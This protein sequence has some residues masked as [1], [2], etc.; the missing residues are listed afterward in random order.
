VVLYEERAAA[1]RLT[2]APNFQGQIYNEA[3]PDF[4]GM[5]TKCGKVLSELESIKQGN[6]QDTSKFSDTLVLRLQDE[7]DSR[8]ITI[9]AER[10]EEIRAALDDLHRVKILENNE[11]RRKAIDRACAEEDEDNNEGNNKQAR[12]T[13]IEDSLAESRAQHD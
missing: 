10:V 9:M 11:D 4:Q 2:E 5:V 3:G 12:K 7:V 1:F 8:D 6:T 13:R